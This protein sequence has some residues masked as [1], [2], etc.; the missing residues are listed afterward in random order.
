MMGEL[1]NHL[2]QSTVFAIMAGLLTLAFRK[3]R[4][5]VRY[6]LWFSRLRKFLIRSRCC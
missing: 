5:Q 6:G 3:N 2:W 4:A 1:V